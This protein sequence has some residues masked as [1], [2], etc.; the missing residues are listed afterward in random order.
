MSKSNKKQEAVTN[1]TAKAAKADLTPAE[2]AIR[3]LV[4]QLRILQKGGFG[5]SKPAKKIRRADGDLLD[6]ISSYIQ[7]SIPPC[8]E[9]YHQILRVKT[10][11]VLGHDGG[12]LIRVIGKEI[13]TAMAHH[14]IKIMLREF[15]TARRSAM[16]TGSDREQAIATDGMPYTKEQGEALVKVIWGHFYE[17]AHEGHNENVNYDLVVL[18]EIFRQSIAPALIGTDGAIDGPTLT[19]VPF[20]MIVRG[21][22]RILDKLS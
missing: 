5:M 17:G 18:S 10:K 8:K 14:Q 21:A 12:Q 3:C 2:V 19:K 7:Y 13:K 9:V 22:A 11:E 6:A 4:E 1:N 16:L 15:A 20:N